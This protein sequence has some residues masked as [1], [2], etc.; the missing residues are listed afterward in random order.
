MDLL[1]ME[2]ST[3][4]KHQAMI[5]HVKII[6]IIVSIYSRGRHFLHLELTQTVRLHDCVH[7]DESTDLRSQ[8]HDA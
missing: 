6:K 2:L 1:A 3:I 7:Q 5:D 8:K 4:P